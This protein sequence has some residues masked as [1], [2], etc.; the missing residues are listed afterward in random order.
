MSIAF[1]TATVHA[2]Y[3]TCVVEMSVGEIQTPAL[4]ARLSA[5]KPTT[6]RF[7]P[8]LGSGP[9]PC[10]N[11]PAAPPKGTTPPSALVGKTR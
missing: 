10:P 5:R 8:G 9:P 6:C 1:L 2:Y 11:L 7:F 4:V 3:T